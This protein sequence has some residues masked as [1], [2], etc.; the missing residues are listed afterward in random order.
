MIRSRRENGGFLIR[1]WGEQ[2]T[3]SRISLATTYP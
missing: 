3:I 2:I 1:S